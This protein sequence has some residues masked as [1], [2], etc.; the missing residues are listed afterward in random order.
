MSNGARVAK[1]YAPTLIRP[2]V[3]RCNSQSTLRD[4]YWRLHRATPSALL[5]RTYIDVQ[6]FNPHAP[7]NRHSNCYRKHEQEKKRQYY[8][9]Q[10]VREV[11]HALFTPLVLSA[12]GGMA[13]QATIFYK[14]LAPWSGINNYNSTMNWLRAQELLFH[15]SV[16]QFSV[17]EAHDPDVD[18]LPPQGPGHGAP[19]LCL[20]YT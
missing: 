13:N 17:F 14:R 1:I 11:E 5:D 6:V 19:P 7:S 2:R 9:E 20:N 18:M 4:L 8:Y 3:L 15:F 12:S 16:L 10:R